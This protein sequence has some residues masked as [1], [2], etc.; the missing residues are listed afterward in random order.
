LYGEEK[1]R[2]PT[3]I[4]CSDGTKGGEAVGVASGRGIVVLAGR[5]DA[6]KGEKDL[7][8]TSRRGFLQFRNCFDFD[9]LQ[10]ADCLEIAFNG[11]TG[12]SKVSVARM[13]A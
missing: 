9:W 4:G 7:S 12:L 1:K 13:L 3:V 8:G 10:L 5:L 11:A 2:S 6:L